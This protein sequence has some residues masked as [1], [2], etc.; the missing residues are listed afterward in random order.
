MVTSRVSITLV[1][2][3]NVNIFWSHISAFRCWNHARHKRDWDVFKTLQTLNM[4]FRQK[5]SACS[6]RKMITFCITVFS[7]D[8]LHKIKRIRQVE[9]GFFCLFYLM[10]AMLHSTKERLGLPIIIFWRTSSI[11]ADCQ[12]CTRLNDNCVLDMLQLAFCGPF[13]WWSCSSRVGLLEYTNFHG[14]WIYSTSEKHEEKGT[15]LD[16]F[17]HALYPWTAV[18]AFD[19]YLK[20]C[21]MWRILI[22]WVYI[23]IG[24]G[25]SD[26]VETSN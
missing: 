5:I 11:L 2:F 15:I 7:I 4:S 9:N 10:M 8:R 18:S 3:P 22:M 14:N 20:T 19:L 1:R 23:M 17:L 13:A 25:L 12:H 16:H 21:L 26:V 24:V 6:G